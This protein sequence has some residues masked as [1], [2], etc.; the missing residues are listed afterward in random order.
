[1]ENS[2]EWDGQEAMK[3]EE[4]DPLRLRLVGDS[5]VNMQHPNEKPMYLVKVAVADTSFTH[6]VPRILNSLQ[7][8]VWY[9]RL[10]WRLP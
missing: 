2:P 7:L 4:D 9:P 10:F 5:L 6:A 3:E 8:D 1:M